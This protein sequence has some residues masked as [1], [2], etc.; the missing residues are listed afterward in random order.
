MTDLFDLNEFN[1][2]H[3]PL[4]IGTMPRTLFEFP[5]YGL[6]ILDMP[7]KFP[8]Q[9]P[10]IPDYAMKFGKFINRCLDHAWPTAR[11]CYAYLTVDQ[12]LVKAGTSQRT[13]GAHVDGFQGTRIKDAL[14]H[15]FGYCASNALPTIFYK[16]TWDVAHL[17]KG[18]DNFFL[19]FDRQAIGLAEWQPTP[20]DIV[21]FD[22]YSVH[23]GAV[24]TEDVARTFLRLSFS[25]R[26]YDRLGNS[27]N[28]LLSYGW[29]YERRQISKDLR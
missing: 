13:A 17:D 18:R 5:H 16:Q 23:R 7:I 20:C 29:R 19:E 12:G 15:D 3:D 10:A 4:V 28:P 22:A 2:R 6:R 11:D 24:A 8:N 26:E 21:Y 9:Q 14:P 1:R 27:I 25:V